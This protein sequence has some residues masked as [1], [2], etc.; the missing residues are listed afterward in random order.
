M[1]K[2][3]VYR[4]FATAQ[5]DERFN[6]QQ[7]KQLKMGF[8][9]G[10]DIALYADFR[11]NALQMQEMRL[12]LEK[13]LAVAEFAD[14]HFNTRQMHE[15]MRGQE[16]NL[17]I[18]HYADLPFSAEQMRQMRYGLEHHINVTAYADPELSEKEMMKRLQMENESSSKGA[19]AKDV[20]ETLAPVVA[21][22]QKTSSKVQ[23]TIPNNRYYEE[24]EAMGMSM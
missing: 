2:A 18:K 8:N 9:N 16:K 10:L 6:E 13:G 19:I 23:A 1:D 3:L 21:S 17:A 20:P 15:I 7:L 12:G 24:D 14:Y 4:I 5:E 11:F 22:R